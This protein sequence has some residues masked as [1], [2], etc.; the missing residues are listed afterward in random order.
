ME[1][2]NR[3]RSIRADIQMTEQELRVLLNITSAVVFSPPPLTARTLSTEK[4]TSAIFGNP[5]V[6]AAQQLVSIAHAERAVRSAKALPDLSLGYFNQ[7]LI[8]NPNADG[9]VATA[10]DR[11]SGMKAGI[12]IPL[13]F[14]SHMAGIKAAKVKEQMASD[15]ASY[16]HTVLSGRYERQ[17]LEIQKH[18]SSLDH[19]IRSGLPQA[20]LL[21]RNAEKSYENG[22][23][24]YIEY[25]Q[26]LDRALEIKLNYL[27][28]LHGYNRAVI[29]L[30][31]LLGI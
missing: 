10:S 14:G 16:F 27:I 29:E 9:S 28:A 12:S 31:Y 19:Y 4:D 7:S 18:R 15:R 5:T 2:S 22:A 6:S 26:G 24:G 20:D 23:I 11:F 21:L 25:F 1:V 8:G 17:L 30:E 13:A 3:L